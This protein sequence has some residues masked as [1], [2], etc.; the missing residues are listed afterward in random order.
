MKK[1]LL[2]TLAIITVLSLVIGIVSFSLNESK[3]FFKL[4]FS[5]EVGDYINIEN[6]PIYDWV[7]NITNNATEI[8]ENIFYNIEYIMDN[9]F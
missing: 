2:I 7:L 3:D 4:F 9:M 6:Y 1:T 5:K 8:I